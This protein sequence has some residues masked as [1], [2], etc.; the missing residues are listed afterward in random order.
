[1]TKIDEGEDDLGGISEL[2]RIFWH[3]EGRSIFNKS[4]N[5]QKR[6]KTIIEPI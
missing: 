4:A 6:G 2:K 5:T 1:M 3:L